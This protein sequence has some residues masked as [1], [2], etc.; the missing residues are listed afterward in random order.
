MRSAQRVCSTTGGHRASSHALRGHLEERRLQTSQHLVVGLDD[1]LVCVQQQRVSGARREVDGER[2]VIARL[3]GVVLDADEGAQRSQL[4]LM[5][6]AHQPA[7]DRR[8]ELDETRRAAELARRCLRQF[9]P[10]LLVEEGIEEGDVLRCATAR[11]DQ[12]HAA[13]PV[14]AVEPPSIHLDK[15][16]A[17]SS[18]LELG[19]ARPPAPAERVE[20]CKSILDEGLL[21]WARVRAQLVKIVHER[22]AVGFAL[23]VPPQ[24]DRLVLAVA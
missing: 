16:R 14:A 2:D 19:V 24:C 22:R 17:C 23:R 12:C 5:P 21:V 10:R 13:M 4:L 8:D 18:Q 15:P 7:L 9:V 11:L 3:L 1:G 20:G 6:R